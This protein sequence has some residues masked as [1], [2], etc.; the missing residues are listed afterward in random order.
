MCIPVYLSVRSVDSA[1][2]LSQIAGK[3]IEL[4]KFSETPESEDAAALQLEHNCSQ[5]KPSVNRSTDQTINE[6]LNRS[7]VDSPHLHI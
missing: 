3:N 6:R 7:I 2:S 1:S 4:L 5:S